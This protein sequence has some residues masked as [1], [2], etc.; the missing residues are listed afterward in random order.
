MLEHFFW[1][2][3]MNRPLPRAPLLSKPDIPP[4]AQAPTKRVLTREEYFYNPSVEEVIEYV[5]NSDINLTE[6]TRM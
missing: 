4:P 3:K 6:K 2:R 1:K 5:K